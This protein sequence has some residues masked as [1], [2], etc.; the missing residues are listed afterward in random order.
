MASGGCEGRA[1][2]SQ[3]ARNAGPYRRRLPWSCSRSCGLPAHRGTK[4]PT[5]K[6][7]RILEKFDRRIQRLAFRGH[8]RV[9]DDKD[10]TLVGP[11]E[12]SPGAVWRPRQ[13]SLD[14][15]AGR[16]H[17]CGLE[18]DFR[19]LWARAVFRQPSRYLLTF[20]LQPAQS[21][22]LRGGQQR[23]YG[24]EWADWAGDFPT[25]QYG[26]FAGVA[27]E[28]QQRS[29]RRRICRTVRTRSG[30]CPS[31]GVCRADSLSAW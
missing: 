23:S 2:N 7:L 9:K 31:R 18:Q 28:P 27:R 10:V 24:Q 8:I 4:P 16:A 25:P 6:L 20:I 30:C 17:A 14:R 15:A 11:G 3:A 26:D 21:V 12:V 22:A 1:G 13:Q 19:H 29:S 5:S